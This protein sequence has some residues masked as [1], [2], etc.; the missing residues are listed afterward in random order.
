MPEGLLQGIEE[1]QVRDLIAYLMHPVQVPFPGE[2][3]S[4]TSGKGGGP[5]Q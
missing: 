3:K 5:N 2:A 4:P 1:T